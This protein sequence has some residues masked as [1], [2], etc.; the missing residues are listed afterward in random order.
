MKLWKEHFL[1]RLSIHVTHVNNKFSDG[2]QEKSSLMTVT[3]NLLRILLVVAYS[4]QGFPVGVLEVV[5]GSFCCQSVCEYR[6]G[7]AWRTA[8]KSQTIP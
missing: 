1:E 5:V 6:S 3:E 4:S 8:K 2:L 7:E